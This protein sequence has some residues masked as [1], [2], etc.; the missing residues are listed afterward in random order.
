M[1]IE[2]SDLIKKLAVDP[3]QP[4]EISVLQGYVGR[5]CNPGKVRLY[6]TVDNLDE[7]LELQDDASIR[8][9]ETGCESGSS[10]IYVDATATVHRVRVAKAGDIARARRKLQLN[11]ETIRS[12][13]GAAAETQDRALTAGA[14]NI[15]D[16]CTNTCQSQEQWKCC[17][18]LAAEASCRHY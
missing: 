17:N 12:L 2:E 1:K 13:R 9:V 6:S 7:Y 3:E 18:S 15:S 8:H 16:R 11:A 4:V 14:C 10:R 5:S